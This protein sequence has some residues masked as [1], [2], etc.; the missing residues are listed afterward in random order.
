MSSYHDDVD[1]PGYNDT[2]LGVNFARETREEKE[3]RKIELRISH[4][5]KEI[6]TLQADN[7]SL[8]ARDLEA[9]NDSLM[10]LA[11]FGRWALD[12][13][14]QGEL[15][16][17]SKAIELGLLVEVIATEPCGDECSCNT[18]STFPIECLQLTD[19]AKVLD[20]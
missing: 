20:K 3:M 9:E 8:L 17:L 12:R 6:A 7:A 19:K 5:N 4:A 11:R 13:R 2:N 14:S 18:W 15:T 10:A 16:D 1:S